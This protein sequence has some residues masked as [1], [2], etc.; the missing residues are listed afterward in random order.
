MLIKLTEVCNNGA[1]TTKQNYALR[2]IFVNPEHVVMIREDSS[3]RKLNEQGRLLGNLDPQ[4]RFSK[5]IINKGHTGTEIR[6]VGAPEII[7]NILNKKH[8]KELLRG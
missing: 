7:E 4:H 8:T 3:L 6:V 2:E 5:L 1:V